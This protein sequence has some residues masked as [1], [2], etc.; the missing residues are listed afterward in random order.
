[1]PYKPQMKKLSK[2]A[3]DISIKHA[4]KLAKLKQAHK[5]LDRADFVWHFLLLSFSTM[6]GAGGVDGLIK[7][8][9]NYSKLKFENLDKLDKKQRK[10]VILTT[11]HAAKIRWPNKKYEFIYQC[12]ERVK[13]L[14][15][16]DK[17]KECLFAQ[18][19]RENKISF[20][21]TFPGIGQKYARNILMD[22]Y[23]EEFRNS[24]AIDARIK[25]VSESL[26]VTFDN[27]SE[28]E[29]FYIKA[30][31][32]AGINGWEMDRLLFNFKD[33]FLSAI[34]ALN[35]KCS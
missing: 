22:V 24:I 21:M 29:Q 13:E 25:K 16:L 26:G 31:E 28:H 23:H 6:G 15:G 14:G 32:M 17:V 11:C 10:K 30:S 19:G 20:L 2:I 18:K 3:K 12:F 27:Y 5:E 9:N 35:E 1:M 33:E 34:G 7:D 4:D 8:E